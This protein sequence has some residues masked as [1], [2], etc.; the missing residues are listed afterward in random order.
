MPSH[1]HWRGSRNQQ[2]LPIACG[3]QLCQQHP[4]KQ[5]TLVRSKH[6]STK[7]HATLRERLHSNT[8][9]ALMNQRDAWCMIRGVHNY[10]FA[11]IFHHALILLLTPTHMHVY[12]YWTIWL[13]YNSVSASANFWQR[14]TMDHVCGPGCDHSFSWQSTRVSQWCRG[15]RIGSFRHIMMFLDVSIETSQF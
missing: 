3:I 1:Y 11:P 10:N 14:I 7:G 6:P 13:M 15:H 8:A 12:Q 4:T 5:Y 2:D 9:L